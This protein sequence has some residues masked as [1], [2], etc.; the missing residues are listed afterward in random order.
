MGGVGGV[1]GFGWPFT[2]VKVGAERNMIIF[3]WQF[4]GGGILVVIEKNMR[5]IGWQ[6]TGPYLGG[7][8]IWLEKYAGIWVAIRG[9][10]G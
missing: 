2:K 6:F 9:G 10:I 3:G 8:L 7:R 4:T 5:I 1:R